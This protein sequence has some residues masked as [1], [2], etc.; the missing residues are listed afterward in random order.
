[1]GGTLNGFQLPI[2]AFYKCVKTYSFDQ[3]S[4]NRFTNLY[5]PRW[6][7][8]AA[9]VGR[10]FSCICMSVSLFVSAL[11]GKRLELS[12]PNLVH[13]YSIAVA[14]HALTQSQKIK[15]K[16]ARLQNPHSDAYSYSRVLLLPAWVCM[17]IRLP[18]FSS[19]YCYY[20][21]HENVI[22]LILYYIT[23][24]SNW[25][26][27]MC[28]YSW[29]VTLYAVHFSGSL[30]ECGV[31]DEPIVPLPFLMVTMHCGSWGATT[32]VNHPVNTCRHQHKCTPL[33]KH[34]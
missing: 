12:A 33:F 8:I 22:N 31:N 30:L 10:A 13:I 9:G 24:R 26:W 28:T 21:Y 6:G 15:V 11:K 25:L 34:L 7:V 32:A 18:M 4:V 3:L 17:S 16:V 27:C 5:Y 23:V 2:T 1:L 29:N 19:S 20:Y 14:R